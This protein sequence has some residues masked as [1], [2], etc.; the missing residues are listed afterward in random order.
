MSGFPGD[1]LSSCPCPYISGQL[2][3]CH[4]VV[5][6]LYW[7]MT[8]YVT[9]KVNK[10]EKHPQTLWV[11][12][13]PVIM[14]PGQTSPRD[15]TSVHK[16]NFLEQTCPTLSN[17]PANPPVSIFPSA[18][19]VWDYLDLHHSDKAVTSRAANITHSKTNIRCIWH[20]CCKAWSDQLGQCY[21]TE[22]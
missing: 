12:S 16:I 14:V 18:Y 2:N 13:L 1:G 21:K 19:C 22:I 7:I 9:A 20:E 11:E 6:V 8:G 5:F 15:A 10:H 17:K 3:S 4:E